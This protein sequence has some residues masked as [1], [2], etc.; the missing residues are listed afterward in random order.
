MKKDTMPPQVRSRHRTL[1]KPVRGGITAP[2]GFLANAAACRIKKVDKPDLCLIF[3]EVPASA[4]GVF[5]RNRAVAAPILWT[6]KI[7]QRPVLRAVIANSG[8]A[9]ACT[10][11]KGRHDAEAMAL[12]AAAALSIRKQEVAV[13]STGVIGLP[14]PMDR[15]I[16]KIPGLAKSLS[17]SGGALAARAIM[18]TDTRP[19][20]ASFEWMT[21]GRKVR[22][23][24]MAKGSG[25]IHPDM[26]TMLAF[27][28][29]DAAVNPQTLASA[30]KEAVDESFNR[31]T[32]DGDMSTNDMVLV[33]AN[34]LSGA[35]IHKRNLLSSGF[36]QALNQVCLGLA[37]S[38]VKDGEGATKFVT[39]R[40]LHGKNK[41]DCI[42]I[43][44]KIACSNLVKT[45]LFGED[46]NW[47]R[48][49]AAAGASG[50]P[51]H[52]E[53]I[54]IFFDEIPMVRR[55]EGLGTRQ[56]KKAGRILR[57]KEFVITVDLHMGTSSAEIYTTDLSLDYVKI[58]ADYRS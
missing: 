13:A 19:K 56:E 38:I 31:I 53:K 43:A 55:G 47:G 37:L 25:M 2:A 14:L 54:D 11:L 42:T 24:A 15:I 27:V 57:K 58:N 21:G 30:L 33:L 17:R 50:V 26:A 5:T 40:T 28:T 48:I 49:M 10:G 23:G 35:R 46:A 6:R 9:N 8:N 39:I 22:I 29:T 3:S 45:A 7:L 4:A 36:Q 12:H 51:I 41:K 34:G 16:P 18:T 1:I 20:T 44:R 52:P 32:V